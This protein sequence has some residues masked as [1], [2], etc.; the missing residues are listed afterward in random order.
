MT[1]ECPWD[2]SIAVGAR[3]DSHMPVA[4]VMLLLIL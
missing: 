3:K 4:H 1:T 2:D